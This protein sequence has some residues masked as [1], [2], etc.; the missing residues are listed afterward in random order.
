MICILAGN[1]L[2]AKKWAY[3]Q[4]LGYEEWFYPAN[5]EDLKHRSNFH[6]LVIGSAGYNVPDGYFES[7]YSLAQSRG[8]IG[9]LK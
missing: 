9:R 5:P 2:E 3:G 4:Q 6:V 8:K 7:V 1:Y